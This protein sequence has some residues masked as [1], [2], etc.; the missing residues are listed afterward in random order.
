MTSPT[1][2]TVTRVLIRLT[3]HPMSPQLPTFPALPPL[4]SPERSDLQSRLESGLMKL[5]QLASIAIDGP[6]LEPPLWEKSKG[7]HPLPEKQ[8]LATD[9]RAFPRRSGRCAVTVCRW[10]ED[11]VKT[12]QQLE[13]RLHASPLK[14][15]LANLSLNGA[16][17]IL[18]RQ[19]SKAETLLV[20]LSC[21][22][23]AA[24]LDQRAKVVDCLPD[25]NGQ[26]RV[27]CQFLSKLN[28]DQV[29]LFRRFLDNPHWI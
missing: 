13:W 18:P 29:S 5:D 16:A 26:Y 28:L 1:P 12:Q 2:Q 23:R 19:I 21:P 24:S 7:A 6:E 15:E 27:L 4:K 25:E 20:R 11:D 14:G 10:S 9:R 17:L 8:P 22:Q 3:K